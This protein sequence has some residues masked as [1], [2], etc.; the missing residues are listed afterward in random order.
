MKA[1]QAFRDADVLVA[2]VFTQKGDFG[3]AEIRGL[4]S[5]PTS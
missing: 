2:L 4:E 5:V 1:M 3:Q